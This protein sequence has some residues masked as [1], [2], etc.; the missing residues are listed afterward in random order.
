MHGPLPLQFLAPST[1]LSSSACSHRSLRVLKLLYLEFMQCCFLQLQKGCR[2]EVCVL[3]CLKSDYS[4]STLTSNVDQGRYPK[5][6]VVAD[7]KS[8]SYN[9]RSKWVVKSSGSYALPGPL[10][11]RG[12]QIGLHHHT[13][14][15]DNALWHSFHS[16]SFRSPFS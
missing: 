16:G 11:P 15:L 1:S 14:R 12:L 8:R 4:K 2:G 7:S 6:L 3:T 10:V 9:L 13:G 5:N